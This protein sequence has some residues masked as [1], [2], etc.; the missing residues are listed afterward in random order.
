MYKEAVRKDGDGKDRATHDL[1]AACLGFPILFPLPFHRSSF[2]RA[3][4]SHPLP[5]LPL[6]GRARQYE[7]CGYCDGVRLSTRT[8]LLDISVMSHYGSD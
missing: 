3:F 6:M 1:N 2:I 8:I 4:I 7:A 5:R